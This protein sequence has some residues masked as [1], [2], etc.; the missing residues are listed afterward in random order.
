MELAREIF[1]LDDSVNE[2]DFAWAARV[3]VGLDRLVDDFEL[4]SSPTTTAGS[5]A[6]STSDS[7]PA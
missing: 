4:D 3:S 7:A 5:T 2:D 1:V 6:S